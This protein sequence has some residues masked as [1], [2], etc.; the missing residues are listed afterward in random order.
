M[1]V[2][3]LLA[4]ISGHRPEATGTQQRR[5]SVGLPWA[6]R[7]D[8]FPIRPG[9]SIQISPLL[10]TVIAS[11]LD[12][13]PAPKPQKT[14]EAHCMDSLIWEQL[15]PASKKAE[16]GFSAS[17]FLAFPSSY[18][19][20]VLFTFKCYKTPEKKLA[21]VSK[22]QTLRGDGQIRTRTFS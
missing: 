5:E 10:S 11:S 2:H 18:V 12:P 8:V 15:E 21:L 1:C 4:C 13:G 17:G 19:V 9:K 22:T 3:L 6:F 14:A 16:L 20:Q 7:Q